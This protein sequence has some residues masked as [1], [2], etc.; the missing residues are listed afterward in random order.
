MN[1]VVVGDCLERLGDLPDASVDLVYADPPYGT[2]KDWGEF[3][4]RWQGLVGYLSYMRPRLEACRRVLAETGSL[5]LHCDPTAGAYLRVMCDQIWGRENF[6]NEIVWDYKKVSNS[7]ARKFLRA[8]DTI[9]FY[10]KSEDY[11]YHELHETG[12]S[13]RKL[14][15]VEQGYNTKRMNG[16]RY[17]YVYDQDKVDARV[18]YGRL[19]LEDFD[20]IRRVDVS[21]GTRH[22]DIFRID[23]LNPMSAE[24]T[25]YPT[26]KPVA[27]PERIVRASTNEG[28]L[29]C[30]PFCGSGTTLVAAKRLGRRWWGCD[31]NPQA[32]T[33][34]EQRLVAEPEPLPGLAGG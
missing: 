28:D 33:I 27:L 10:T 26:Q 7:T 20:H 34:T 31:R 17:L 11:T 13:P 8:H 5:Y 3:D 30:D 18:A 12:L 24:A 4:D 15:L 14:E 19:R 21:V 16:E 29:V 1:R 32:V 23:L 25:G 22:T 2:G 6:R 9:L